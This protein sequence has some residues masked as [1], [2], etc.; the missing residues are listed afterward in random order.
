M[1][2]ISGRKLDRSEVLSLRLDVYVEGKLFAD[3][4]SMLNEYN[5]IKLKKKALNGVRPRN[6]NDKYI[7][8]LDCLLANLI[9]SLL[10]GLPLAIGHREDFFKN[11]NRRN[12]SRI[13]AY[14][15]KA[16]IAFLK[17]SEIGLIRLVRS[18]YYDRKRHK[19]SAVSLY[20]PS[21]SFDVFKRIAASKGSRLVIRRHSNRDHSAARVVVYDT[22]NDGIRKYY[23]LDSLRPEV[24]RTLQVL[25]SLDDVL[26]KSSF[27]IR[28]VSFEAPLFFRCFSSDYSEHGRIYSDNGTFQNWKKEFIRELTIDGQK[29]IELDFASTHTAIAYALEG[30][31]LPN[32]DVYVLESLSA[33]QDAEIRR[34]LGKVFTNILLNAP[35]YKVAAQAIGKAFAERGIKYRADFNISIPRVINEIAS[36]HRSIAKHFFTGAGLRLMKLESDICLEIVDRFCQL[37][38]PI[39]PKHDSFVVKSEDEDLLRSEMTSAWVR[40]ISAKRPPHE[41]VQDPN[42]SR[43]NT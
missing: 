12:P 5:R 29:T 16:L 7:V 10:Q 33:I 36:K 14:I 27:S 38:K 9:E 26:L 37:H 17:G 6:R 31:Q 32:K 34:S 11:K 24:I 19:N 23:E 41:M 40:V 8:A 15:F 42:I 21:Q 13:T 25:T 18:G 39:I 28:D 30:V 20:A 1:S 43:K 22:T 35:S 4:H 2:K 3:I